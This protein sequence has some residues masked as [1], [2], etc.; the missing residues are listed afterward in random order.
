[1]SRKEFIFASPNFTGDAS[2]TNIDVLFTIH[3][4]ASFRKIG[5]L[6]IPH[7]SVRNKMVKM[8]PVFFIKQKGFK[9]SQIRDILLF[10]FQTVAASI[11]HWAELYPWNMLATAKLKRLAS[12][13][14]DAAVVTNFVVNI[15][16]KR[17]KVLAHVHF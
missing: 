3:V 11:K 17:F 15:F 13:D 12:S 7:E 16:I 2:S 14:N 1:M 6:W 4:K 10:L 8:L 9:L 5:W